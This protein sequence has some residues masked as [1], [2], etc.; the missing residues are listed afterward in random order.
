MSKT[1]IGLIFIS[2]GLAYGSLAVDGVY[3]ATLGY[4]L[5]HKWLTPPAIK[6]ITPDLLGRKPSILIYS[7]VLILI[8]LYLIWSHNL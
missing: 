7:L 2:F 3:N 4:L 1:T 6:K 5:E 8:G